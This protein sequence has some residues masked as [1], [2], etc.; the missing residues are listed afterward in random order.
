MAVLPV[1]KHAFGRFMD[2]DESL[3]AFSALCTLDRQMGRMF[4]A[5]GIEITNYSDAY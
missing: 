5:M 2:V 1:A 4:Q 3:A